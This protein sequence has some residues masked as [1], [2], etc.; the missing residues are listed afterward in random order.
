MTTTKVKPKEVLGDDLPIL[1]W[2]I[3]RIMNN[4]SYQVD[5]K[6]EWVQWVTTDVNRTSLKSITQA[7]AKKIMLAQTG[8]T[9]V[10]EPLENWA[11]FDKKNSK[12]RRVLALCHQAQWTITNEK[13]GEVADLETLNSWLHSNLCP[14]K[15]PLL[16]MDNNTELPKIIKALEGVVKSRYK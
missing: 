1:K 7:Q 11:L 3:N 8:A 15:K 16:K 5:T 2:Q 10:S 13:Y 12:H 14:V 4:C 9:P 6:N